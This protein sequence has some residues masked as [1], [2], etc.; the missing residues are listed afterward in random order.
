[1]IMMMITMMLV[2]NVG[3]VICDNMNSTKSLCW[4]LTKRFYFLTYLIFFELKKN[5]QLGFDTIIKYSRIK[6]K[7]LQ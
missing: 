5:D 7:K 6:P 4:N 1:M 2:M 3:D